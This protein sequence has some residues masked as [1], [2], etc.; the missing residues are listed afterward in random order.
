MDKQ[1]K[2]YPTVYRD[3]FGEE[4][5]VIYNDGKTLTMTLRG[6]EFKAWDIFDFAKP[7]SGVIEQL[8]SFSFCH[9]YLCDYTLECSGPVQVVV[10]E[11]EKETE[12]KIHIDIGKPSKSEK[13]YLKGWPDPVILILEMTSSKQK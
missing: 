6:V 5:T 10:G 11:L 3:K 12:L 4:T 13:A 8:S 7:E 2:Q 9:D 1:I